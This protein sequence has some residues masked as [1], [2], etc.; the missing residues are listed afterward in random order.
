MASFF[1]SVILTIELRHLKPIV[2]FFLR[3]VILRTIRAG[4]AR[5]QAYRRACA[6][7]SPWLV[8]G[9]FFE[10]IFL[11][12]SPGF[13]ASRIGRRM[14]AYVLTRLS[15]ILRSCRPSGVV[16]QATPEGIANQLHM[17]WRCRGAAPRVTM[18][19]NH[20]HTTC[21]SPAFQPSDYQLTDANR[22]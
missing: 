12:G 3:Y 20:R 18:L 6:T 14:R 1:L 7:R 2:I 16:F 11:S 5:L 19:I 21:V 8:H 17:N 22:W 13:E 9:F 15:P 4:Q 10:E